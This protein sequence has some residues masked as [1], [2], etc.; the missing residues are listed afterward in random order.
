VAAA[1][2]CQLCRRLARERDD[3][4][5]GMSALGPDDRGR[6]PVELAVE[7]GAGLLVL[8]VVRSN[9]GAAC[10]SA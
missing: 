8:A 5:D 10:G 2:D 1:A 3:T 7:D 4:R 6:A 9:D